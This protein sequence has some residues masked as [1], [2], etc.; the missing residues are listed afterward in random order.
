MPTNYA[1]LVLLSERAGRLDRV[2]RSPLL[3]F[4]LGA[5]LALVLWVAIGWA[6]IALLG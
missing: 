1:D 2:T 5:G 6:A 4:V 3:G